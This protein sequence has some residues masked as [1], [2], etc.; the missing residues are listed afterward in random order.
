[1]PPL[2]AAPITMVEKTIGTTIILI[3]LMN[4][5]PIGLSA[6]PK[7]GKKWP[8]RAPITKAIMI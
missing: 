2:P 8:I 1:M 6:I 7:S 5:S 4:P 3:S